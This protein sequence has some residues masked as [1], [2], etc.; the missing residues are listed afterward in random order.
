M[1]VYI[2]L[3]TNQ[4]LQMWKTVVFHGSQD[5]QGSKVSYAEEN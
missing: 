2:N 4:P 1:I 5:P 3:V